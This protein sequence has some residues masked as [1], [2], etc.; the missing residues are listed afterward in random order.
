[1]KNSKLKT[2]VN[3]IFTNNRL[4]VRLFDLPSRKNSFC[5]DY[6]YT[7]TV[8]AFKTRMLTDH[9]IRDYDLYLKFIQFMRTEITTN[10]TK[11]TTKR[12]FICIYDDLY[13]IKTAKLMRKK[14]YPTKEIEHAINLLKKIQHNRYKYNTKVNCFI[15]DETYH[16]DK[17]NRLI[18]ARNKTARYAFLYMTHLAEKIFIKAYGDYIIKEKAPSEIQSI[19]YAMSKTNIG[20]HCISDF[21]SYESSI[22]HHIQQNC[23]LLLFELCFQIESSTYEYLKQHFDSETFYKDKYGI[24]Y[25]CRTVR[26]SGDVW[27]SLGNTLLNICLTKFLINESQITKYKFLCEGDDLYM[28]CDKKPDKKILENI[29]FSTKMQIQDNSKGLDFLSH[30]VDIPQRLPLIKKNYTKYVTIKCRKDTN[31]M[32]EELVDK[33]FAYDF[34]L[35]NMPILWA[36]NKKI[37]SHYMGTDLIRKSLRKYV[38]KTRKFRTDEEVITYDYEFSLLRNKPNITF[39]I[40]KRFFEQTGIPPEMQ[41]KLERM[42]FPSFTETLQP[43]KHIDTKILLLHEHKYN[44]LSCG[45]TIENFDKYNFILVGNQLYTLNLG[46]FK[47]ENRE[48]CH[49]FCYILNTLFNMRIEKTQL[50]S[51]KHINL[52]NNY[53]QI[54]LRN[55]IDRNRYTNIFGLLKHKCKSINLLWLDLECHL[56]LSDAAEQA[57]E[58]LLDLDVG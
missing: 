44:P 54:L 4:Y 35:I 26:N 22:N 8:K 46:L 15:K 14:N 2:T 27:T 10:I 32:I 55:C 43:E 48:Y 28:I 51:Q 39:E 23:E 21:T 45:H 30:Y 19:T 16:K 25:A 24:N 40:R 18:S 47:M 31:L 33:A 41:I 49:K 17:S 53:L 3:N 11:F 37:L 34:T 56:E 5:P 29:G 57:N 50:I 1:M 42:I 52:L 38:D 12:K 13:I 6:C 20:Y 58:I 36:L 9:V 7:E